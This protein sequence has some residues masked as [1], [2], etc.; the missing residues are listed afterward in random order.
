MHREKPIHMMVIPYEKPWSPGEKKNLSRMCT[1]GNCQQE[2]L[3][4]VKITFRNEEKPN[5]PSSPE[6]KHPKIPPPKKQKPKPKLKRSHL[7]Q[8]CAK[9]RDEGRSINRK[10]QEGTQETSGSRTQQA[11]LL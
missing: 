1:E 6:K 3:Y 2:I 11:K 8:M 7:Q 10:T 5:Y 4:L 9:G